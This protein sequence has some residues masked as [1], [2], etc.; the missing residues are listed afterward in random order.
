MVKSF[1]E[2][3]TV[4][5]RGNIELKITLVPKVFI[6]LLR[7]FRYFS[8][9]I[10]QLV[11]SSFIWVLLLMC[12]DY[13]LVNW[14]CTSVLIQLSYPLR[15]LST[16]HSDLFHTFSISSLV[17]QLLVKYIPVNSSAFKGRI[18]QKRNCIISPCSR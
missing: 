15:S 17:S 14:G 5:K 1:F 3:I 13:W 10:G 4:S 9:N 18:L 2:N 11:S 6:R 16:L 8:L 12:S 7:N